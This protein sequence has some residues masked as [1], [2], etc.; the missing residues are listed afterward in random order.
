MIV[1]I[2]TFFVRL[3]LNGFI[4][5][6]YW[7]QIIFKHLIWP[8][9]ETLTDSM[10]ESQSGPRSNDNEGLL[11]DIPFVRRKV[12]LFCRGYSPTDGINIVVCREVS[13]FQLS[14]ECIKV[15]FTTRSF[16]AECELKNPFGFFEFCIRGCI[17]ILMVTISTRFLTF[18]EKH[19]WQQI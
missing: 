8:I 19:V 18:S 3:F 13:K 12:L 5:Q 2:S 14:V 6:S 17:L 15:I 9:N 4:P 7:M 11:Q 10:I 16:L 1:H